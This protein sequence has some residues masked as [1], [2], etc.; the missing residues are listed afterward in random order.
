MSH[1]H[2]IPAVH[3]RDTLHEMRSRMVAK[4]GAHIT[5]TQSVAREFFHVFV[6]GLMQ[7]VNL[8]LKI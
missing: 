3:A 1:L 6:S 2:F 8:Q 4:I 5:N 7:N